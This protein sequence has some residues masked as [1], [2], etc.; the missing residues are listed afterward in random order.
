MV[1][2]RENRWSTSGV[3][4]GGGRAIGGE[5]TEGQESDTPGRRPRQEEQD[6]RLEIQPGVLNGT[7]DWIEGE[8]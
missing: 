1:L 2:D 4:L 5:G 8:Q 3:E 7:R 6:R